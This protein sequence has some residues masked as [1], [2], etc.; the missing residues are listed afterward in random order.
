MTW[1]FAAVILTIS[2]LH[3][4]V[5][6]KRS[7]SGR[8][9]NDLKEFQIQAEALMTEFNRIAARNISILDERLE[10]LDHKIRISQKMDHV[11]KERLEEMYKTTFFKSI[12]EPNNLDEIKEASKQQSKTSK[13]TKRS[14]KTSSTEKTLPIETDLVESIL[15]EL[16]P[17]Q[18]VQQEILFEGIP[19]EKLKKTSYRGVTAQIKYKALLNYISEKKSKEELLEL[20]FSINEI[21]LAVLTNL[22][23]DS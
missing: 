2:I 20:G 14:L 18:E 3:L 17:R 11:L 21:N 13:Q 22:K 16:P 4:Y 9:D 1:I 10:E 5:I 19:V 7:P 6:L 15:P 8:T 23:Q 12:S